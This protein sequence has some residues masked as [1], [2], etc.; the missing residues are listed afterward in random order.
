MSSSAGL[1]RLFLTGGHLEATRRK[2]SDD[3]GWSFG[4]GF[5]GIF[6]WWWWWVVVFGGGAEEASAGADWKEFRYE[7]TD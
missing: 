7:P 6:R 1:G 3:L 4:V 5:C 2:A